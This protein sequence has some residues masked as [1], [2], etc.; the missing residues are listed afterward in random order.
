MAAYQAPLSMGFSR[1]EHWS[2]LPLPSPD[3]YWYSGAFFKDSP[4]PGLMASEL[5]SSD[6][7]VQRAGVTYPWL[8]VRPTA[9][10][11]FSFFLFNTYN[12]LNAMPTSLIWDETSLS[13]FWMLLL[14]LFI[15][16]VNCK[17]EEKLLVPSPVHSNWGQV[18]P[19]A[20]LKWNSGPEAEAGLRT[21]NP[22]VLPQLIHWKTLSYLGIID[23][24]SNAY[25]LNT[26]H[27]LFVN[28]STLRTYL[29]L[30]PSVNR[31]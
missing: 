12:S 16:L 29:P 18:S 4:S 3:F 25:S 7:R 15:F 9:K 17:H 11:W 13:S 26:K 1:Q 23:F 8:S 31:F 20:K 24:D 14:F 27:T 28:D 30:V 19:C 10:H 5:V 22:L 2:G 6:L 21:Q